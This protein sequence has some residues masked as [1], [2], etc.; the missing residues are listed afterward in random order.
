LTTASVSQIPSRPAPPILLRFPFK[1]RQVSERT[2]RLCSETAMFCR[3]YNDGVIKQH[4]SVKFRER[5]W[6]TEKN[7]LDNTAS[8]QPTVEPLTYRQR[9]GPPSRNRKTFLNATCSVVRLEGRLVT[10]GLPD[11]LTASLNTEGIA[12]FP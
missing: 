9:A 2:C 3:I 8:K 4:G 11:I 12:A 10:D 6:T 7:S 1:P 5:R